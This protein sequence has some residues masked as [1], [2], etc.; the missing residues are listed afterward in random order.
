MAG[1]EDVQGSESGMPLV[2]DDDSLDGGWIGF[3]ED[4]SDQCPI[5]SQFD[6]NESDSEQENS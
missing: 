1:V 4:D 5:G 2:D 6:D 3:Q